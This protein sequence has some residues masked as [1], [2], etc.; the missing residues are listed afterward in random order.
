MIHLCFFNA[1]KINAFINTGL[2]I[3]KISHTENDHLTLQFPL[4]SKQHVNV[5]YLSVLVLYPATLQFWFTRH[6][7]PQPEPVTVKT[8]VPA[9]ISQPST[10][11][12]AVEASNQLINIVEHMASKEQDTS[13]R[14]W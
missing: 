14:S 3:L 5:I 12:Q 7:Q 11:Q 1:A 4:G 8:D 9:V 6:I 13:L 10:K 2:C